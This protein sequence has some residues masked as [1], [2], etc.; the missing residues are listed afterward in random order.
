[1][2]GKQPRLCEISEQWS[3]SRI[4]CLRHVSKSRFLRLG[5]FQ[6]FSCSGFVLTAVESKVVDLAEGGYLTLVCCW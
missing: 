1:M 4:V 2:C 3:A 6:F 5:R